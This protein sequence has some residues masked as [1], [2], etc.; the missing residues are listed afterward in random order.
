MPLRK[1][2]TLIFVA[3]LACHVYRNDFTSTIRV[4]LSE[5]SIRSLKNILAVRGF[6]CKDCK[7]KEN[8]LN[9]ALQVRAKSRTVAVSP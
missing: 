1:Y 5:L 8:L 6:V 3:D 9:G 2:P 7:T 4:Q